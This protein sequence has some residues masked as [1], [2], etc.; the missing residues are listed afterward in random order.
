[1]TLP[2]TVVACHP[3]LMLTGSTIPT[4][5]LYILLGL[6]FSLSKHLMLAHRLCSLT[7]FFSWTHLYLSALSY[8]NILLKTSL[9]LVHCKPPVSFHILLSAPSVCVRV[10]LCMSDCV[11]VSVCMWMCMCTHTC[12]WKPEAKIRCLPQLHYVLLFETGSLIGCSWF[13]WSV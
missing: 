1:M 8:L 13:G 11:C 7:A 10:C 9:S 2:L 4:L 12:L 6:G 3:V 5:L